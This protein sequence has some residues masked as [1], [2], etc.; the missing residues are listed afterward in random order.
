M[1]QTIHDKAGG[2]DAQCGVN[3]SAIGHQLSAIS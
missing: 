1:E 2:E 3:L